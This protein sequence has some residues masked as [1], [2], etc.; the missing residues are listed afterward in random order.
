MSLHEK[1]MQIKQKERSE[2]FLLALLHSLSTCIG[3][4]PLSFDKKYLIFISS[5]PERLNV[6][7]QPLYF[8]TVV[9]DGC[10][11]YGKGRLAA[12]PRAALYLSVIQCEDNLGR[13]SG[14]INKL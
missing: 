4:V 10:K 14:A 6:T 1:K 5:S 3:C 12:P 7:H 2:I 13:A 8:V 11:S 9:A